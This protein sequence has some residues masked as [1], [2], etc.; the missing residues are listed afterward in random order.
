M[1]AV[2]SCSLADAGVQKPRPGYAVPPSVMDW[3]F[4]DQE[5]RAAVDLE[6]AQHL[7]A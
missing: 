6:Q 2:L 1:L 4:A 3:D 7:N 5:C